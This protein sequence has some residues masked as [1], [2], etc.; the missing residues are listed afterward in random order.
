MK[1]D[2][3]Q[4]WGA[5]N[6]AEDH[7]DKPENS[8]IIDAERATEMQ[9]LKIQGDLITSAMGGV[10]PE[11][12]D[13]AKVRDVLDAACGPSDCSVSSGLASASLIEKALH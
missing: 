4:P 2:I 12:S 7:T 1:C 6:V 5:Q 9:R 13:S 8:Y 11:I 10:L 3:Y